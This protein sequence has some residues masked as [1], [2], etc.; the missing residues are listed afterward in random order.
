M[1]NPH[2]IEPYPIKDYGH[3]TTKTIQLIT[4]AERRAYADRSFYL[5]DPDFIKIPSKKLKSK[6]NLIAD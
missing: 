2:T 6:N 5:G 1:I 4:E 3:N